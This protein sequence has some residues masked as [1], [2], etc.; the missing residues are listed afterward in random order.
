MVSSKK[1]GTKS[2][3]RLKSADIFYCIN[4][5]LVYLYPAKQKGIPTAMRFLKLS[6]ILM[7]K[8][9]VQ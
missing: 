3:T 9:Q 2:D 1:K 4:V 7:S 8:K 6:L 5:Q